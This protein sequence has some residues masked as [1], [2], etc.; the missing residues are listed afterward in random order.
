MFIFLNV[1]YSYPKNLSTLTHK[2]KWT[3][4][5]KVK[6]FLLHRLPSKNSRRMT[7]PESCKYHTQSS[8]SIQLNTEATIYPPAQIQKFWQR[9]TNAVKFIPWAVWITSPNFKLWTVIRECILCNKWCFLFLNPKISQS[10]SKLNIS[11]PS[12]P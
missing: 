2:A 12:T 7:P 4:V 11:W 9:L 10:S 5:A 1:I 6:V 8:Y 3:S